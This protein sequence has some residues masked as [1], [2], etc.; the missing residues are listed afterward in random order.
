MQQD[1]HD[2]DDTQTVTLHPDVANEVATL[3]LSYGPEKDAEDDLIT[4][5]KALGAGDED[6]EPI[7]AE[8][9][10]LA[11]DRINAHGG[12]AGPAGNSQYQHLLDNLEMV[13]KQHEG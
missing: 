1:K 6:A 12:A 13:A 11:I 3:L 5:L 9:A 8:Q 10:Q 2:K 7:T 4:R